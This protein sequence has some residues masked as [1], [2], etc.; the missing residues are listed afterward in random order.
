[1]AVD[2]QFMDA[3]ELEQLF[4]SNKSSDVYI[5]LGEMY[6]RRGFPRKA[7]DVLSKGLKNDD[8]QEG[9]LL[10]AQA[11][12]DASPNKAS[13]LNQAAETAQSV[14]SRD[15]NSWQAHRLL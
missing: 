3:E 12:F 7:I 8:T 15:P 14:V 9:Q 13:F 5:P 1:M 6:L 2:Q 10:L 4:R 11:Y